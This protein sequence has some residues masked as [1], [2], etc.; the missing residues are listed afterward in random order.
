MYTFLLLL[1]F[2][3]IMRMNIYIYISIHMYTQ[4]ASNTYPYILLSRSCI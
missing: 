4:V 1:C 3:W 2:R